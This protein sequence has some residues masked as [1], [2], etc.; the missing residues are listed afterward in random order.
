MK[1][2][3]RASEIV[4]SATQ[5]RLDF[6][7]INDRQF[8]IDHL[9]ELTRARRSLGLFQHHDGITGTAR[10]HVVQDYGKKSNII[11]N[12]MKMNSKVFS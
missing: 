3:F 11:E 8:L 10:A 7:H 4:F 2:N 1:I 6:H 12:K 5:I 9:N